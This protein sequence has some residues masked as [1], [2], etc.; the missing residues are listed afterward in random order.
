MK[1][2]ALAIALA[3]LAQAPLHSAPPA[4]AMR[5]LKSNCFSCHND[6]KKKGGLVMT[7]REALSKAGTMARCSI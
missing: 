6:Q 4:D 7:S 5:L 1:R 2:G 3:L